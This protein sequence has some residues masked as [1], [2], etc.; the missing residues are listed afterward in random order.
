MCLSQVW[1]YSR[2]QQLWPQDP[3]LL[4]SLAVVFLSMQ[5]VPQTICPATV[6]VV[7]QE[8]LTQVLVPPVGAAHAGAHS[9]A[10]PPAP[11]VPPVVPLLPAFPALPAPPLVPAPPAMPPD[12][13]LGSE[14][15]PTEC[16]PAPPTP[17]AAPPSSPP[18]PARPPIV[19]ATPVLPAL[20]SVS[21]LP[22]APLSNGTVRVGH[23]RDVRVSGRNRRIGTKRTF[24]MA[25][26]LSYAGSGSCVPLGARKIS[27][28]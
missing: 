25:R 9:G 3:Q 21:E 26:L 20:P 13:P 15:P 18:T 1:S 5:A 7:T 14:P 19:P 11:L 2:R 16:P 23:P 4:A 17:P 22:P 12:P 10:D 28:F 6:Q 27:H 8:P 24:V